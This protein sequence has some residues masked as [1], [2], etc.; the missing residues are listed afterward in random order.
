MVMVKA[1]ARI[2]SVALRVMKN[3]QR[4]SNENSSHTSERT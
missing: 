2:G 4:N 1:N 3:R